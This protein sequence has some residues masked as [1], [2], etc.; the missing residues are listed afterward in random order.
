MS[1]TLNI[2]ELRQTATL[3]NPGQQIPD[4]DGGYTYVYTLCN[5]SQWRCS[6]EKASLRLAE[7]IFSQTVLAHAT[8]IL[9]GRYHPDISTRTR[10]AWTDRSGVV[11]TANVLDTDDTEGAG[12]ETIAL[13]SEIDPPQAPTSVTWV[14]AGWTQ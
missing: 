12:V 3:S 5:P 14:Q 7:K 2:G 9:A 11:H 4:G 13:V 8:H 10:I 1:V 6:I